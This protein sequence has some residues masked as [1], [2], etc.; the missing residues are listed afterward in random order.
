VCAAGACKGGTNTCQ[1]QGD[2]DCKAKEDGD[3]CNGT[4]LCDK[5]KGVCIVNAATVVQCADVFDTTCLANQ[6]QPSTDKCAMTPVWQGNQC[7]GQSVCS[8]GGWCKLGECDEQNLDVCQCQADAD[9]GPFEDGDLCNGTLYCDKAAAKPSC[10]GRNSKSTPPRTLTDETPPFRRLRSA[11]PSSARAAGMTQR[12]F[13]RVKLKSV[14]SLAGLPW[15]NRQPHAG[16]RTMLRSRPVDGAPMPTYLRSRHLSWFRRGD[17]AYLY[18]D[19]YGYLL[20]MSADLKALVDFFATAQPAEAAAQAFA[21]QWPQAQL[22]QF[23]GVFAQQ[24]VLVDPAAQELDG[25]VHMV[26]IKGPWILAWHRDD[27]AVRCVTSRGFGHEPWAQPQFLDLDPWQADLWKA[28]DGERTVEQLAMALCE[29]YDGDPAMDLGRAVVSVA[30]WTHSSRQLT[31]TLPA[32]KSKMSRLP[33]YATSTVPY[34]PF[35]EAATHDDGPLRDLAAYHQTG[36]ADAEAQFEENETTLSHLLSDPHPALDGRT[37]AQTLADVALDRAWA[38]AGRAHI[39]E[40]GGG[41]GRFAE[42]LVTAL[43][44]TVPDLA[45]TV[46]DASPALHSAQVARLAALGNGVHARLG[47]AGALGLP[48]QSVDW[49]VSN[50][51]IA[52]LRIGMVTRPSLDAGT[53]DADTDPEALALV[54]HYGLNCAAAPEPVPIQVGAT[55]LIEQVAVALK[56]GGFALLT[57]FGAK[58]QFPIESTHLDHAEWSVHFG[59]LMR[60]AE[61]LGLTAELVPVPALLGL[62]EDVWVLASNRTQFRNLRF[63]LRSLGSDLPKRAMTPEQFAVFCADKLR[64]DKLEGLQFRPIGERVMGIV[65]GEFKGLVL[66]RPA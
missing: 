60:V 65:P 29:Q 64:A 8:A 7:G 50:E 20:E 22:G 18:H 11:G 14:G 44:Q 63:L 45:Y 27:G 34:A 9:C 24:K 32:P 6:C 49:L 2:A 62:R 28:I 15:I 13:D 58:D 35:D 3:L 25:L 57:E 36:I 53:A 40:V 16:A 33:P 31:R 17:A 41:T 21:G 39:V 5:A 19:L 52:D 38:G 10:G 46:I 12:V 59:H 1:C 55:R 47:D 4:L 43:R 26:P 56:P 30:Q 51:V 61:K 66:G 23:L 37:Y 54:Q 42:Q 48:A